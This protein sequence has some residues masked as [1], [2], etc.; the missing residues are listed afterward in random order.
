MAHGLISLK[1]RSGGRSGSDLRGHCQ[2]RLRRPVLSAGLAIAIQLSYTGRSNAENHLDYKF[3]AYLE[4]NGRIDVLTHSAL[5]EQA[6]MSQ[7]TLKGEYVHDAVSGASPTGAPP[8]PGSSQVPLAHMDDVRNAGNVGIDW[9]YGINT[10][11]PQFAYSLEHDYESIGLS[12]SDAIDLN[13]K[14]TTLSFG[15]AHD[16]DKIFPIFWAGRKEN[17]NS[18]DL[19]IGINQLLSPVSYVSLNFTVG[20]AHGYLSDPYK[21]VRFDGYPDPT[22]TFPENR[23]G[24]KTKEVVF[25]SGT[26]YVAPAHGSIEASYRFYHD[27]YEVFSHTV[28]LSWYQKLGKYVVLSPMFRFYHQNEA[29]FYQTRFNGDPSDPESPVPIP[30]FYSADYRLSALNTF[31]YGLTLT[32][33][34]KEFLHFD[35]GYQRYAMYGLDGVTSAS[36]YPKANIISAGLRLWW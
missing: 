8:P 22:S 14:N 3:N 17:K 4:E 28:T 11:S 36:A 6:I 18:D 26:Y 33:A 30:Q 5:F 24:E 9:H 31:T 27:S 32:V 13:A 23:P 34:I 1:H 2:D 7:L 35:L 15:Y 10:L 12:V 21:R 29:Y 20:R 25:T 19:F 16:F